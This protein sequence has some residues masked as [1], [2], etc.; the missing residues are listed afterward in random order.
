M[1]VFFIFRQINKVLL[2]F[3]DLDKRLNGK[4]EKNKKKVSVMIRKVLVGF[5]VLLLLLVVVGCNGKEAT[6]QD[7]SSQVNG[8]E[9]QKTPPTPQEQIPSQ[10]PVAEQPPAETN[11]TP[12]S[13]NINS[14]PKEQ[15][16]EP[17][18]STPEA[19]GKAYNISITDNGF[20]PKELKIKVGDMVVW[21]NARTGVG[22]QTF[23]YVIGASGACKRPALQ[24]AYPPGIA[25]GDEFSYRFTVSQTC[26]YVDG[27]RTTQSGKVIVGP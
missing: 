7:T 24:S 9:D 17:K 3:F 15:I 23:A 5:A 16:V 1:R 27:I 11:K 2:I 18:N 10:P 21:K 12:E 20:V 13:T 6:P 19:Q 25:V 8:T 4:E 22:K 26:T 14:P